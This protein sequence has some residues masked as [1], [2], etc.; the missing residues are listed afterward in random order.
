MHVSC[1][2]WKERRLSVLAGIDSLFQ[3][4]FFSMKLDVSGVVHSCQ[5]LLGVNLS[6][7]LVHLYFP[8]AGQGLLF[9][10]WW[11]RHLEFQRNVWQW[12]EEAVLCKIHMRDFRSHFWWLAY[13]TRPA[14]VHLVMAFIGCSFD[15]FS[16]FLLSLK[17]QQN[18]MKI[19]FSC[20]HF[21]VGPYSPPNN[22]F[23][24]FILVNCMGWQVCTKNCTWVSD[25]KHYTG[26]RKVK[27]YTRK[28]NERNEWKRLF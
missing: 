4:V 1:K 2:N 9:F 28:T 22:D 6:P 11:Q 8:Y 17:Q 7:V 26:S 5:P 27:T 13:C 23:L 3:Y 18:L 20:I 19:M 24:N 25:C 12:K 16:V 14:S 15:S 21:P 10:R